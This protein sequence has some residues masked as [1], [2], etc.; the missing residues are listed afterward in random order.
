MS[1]WIDACAYWGRWCVRT[2]GVADVETLL[3]K[4]DR[5]NVEVAASFSMLGDVMAHNLPLN[6]VD[7]IFGD[8]GRV[9][10]DA[11]E[12]SRDGQKVEQHV[13]VRRL[14]GH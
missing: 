14:I 5:W 7:H 3:G 13:D 10:A 8:V 6:H 9:V 12:V 11:F 1:G 2:P 4:M